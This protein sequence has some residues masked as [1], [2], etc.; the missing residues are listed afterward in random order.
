[1][2]FDERPIHFCG[3]NVL[4]FLLEMNS[5]EYFSLADAESVILSKLCSIVQIVRHYS[6]TDQLLKLTS[7]TSIKVITVLKP[8]VVLFVK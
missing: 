4:V 2:V 5:T 1:M 3:K 6:F 8:Y 7:V